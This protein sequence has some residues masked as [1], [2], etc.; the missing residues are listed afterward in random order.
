MSAV[1]WKSLPVVG[2]YSSHNR[3]RNWNYHDLNKLVSSSVSTP[4][5]GGEEAPRFLLSP[6]AVVLRNAEIKHIK[7]GISKES[8]PITMVHCIYPLG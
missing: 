6:L 8:M 5:I 3:D 4:M 2:I 7:K 1:Q